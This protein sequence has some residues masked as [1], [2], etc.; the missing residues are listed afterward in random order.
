MIIN[1]LSGRLRQ[2][3]TLSTCRLKRSQVV[4][5]CG[6]FTTSWEVVNFREVSQSQP[7]DLSTRCTQRDIALLHGSVVVALPHLLAQHV[8][9]Y[10]I[11]MMIAFSI[12]QNSQN[13]WRS[14]AYAKSTISIF[15][16]LH[17]PE[18]R[19]C[20]EKGYRKVS[21]MDREVWTS[22]SG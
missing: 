11:I 4:I 9:H 10:L 18:T 6:L 1:C 14:Y 21:K 3:I 12:T 16:K 8:N 13:S 2:P 22:L 17:V 15:W 20:W 19:S 7:P 5:F